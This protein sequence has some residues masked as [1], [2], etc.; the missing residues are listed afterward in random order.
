[1]KGAY[2]KH[3]FYIYEDGSFLDA[4]G[5]FFNKQGYDEFGGHYDEKNIYHPPSEPLP[6]NVVPIKYNPNLVPR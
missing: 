5:Y 4:D 2:D 6:K 1:M 3:G